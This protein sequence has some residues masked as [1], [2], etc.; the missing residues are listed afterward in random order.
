MNSVSLQTEQN[1]LIRMILDI[2]DL[3]VLRRIK[4][5]L[6]CERSA[7]A[8]ASCVCEEAEPYMSKAEILESIDTACKELKLYREGKLQLKNAEELLDEL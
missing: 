3:N 6:L 5:A 7:E 4:E 2:Q 8:T 1:E